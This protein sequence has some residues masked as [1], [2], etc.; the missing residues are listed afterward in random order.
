MGK[1]SNWGKSNDDKS[2][3]SGKSGG[4]KSKGGGG[5]GKGDDGVVGG[6]DSNQRPS[7]LAKHERGDARRDQGGEKGDSRRP[8][9]KS[10]G[11]RTGGRGR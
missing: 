9:R 1:W 7:N 5:K 10:G 2:N 11:G 4:G 6:H 3:E 8:F